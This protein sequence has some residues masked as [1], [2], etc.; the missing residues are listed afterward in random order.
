MAINGNKA[1]YEGLRS[2][3]FGTIGTGYTQIGTNFS[4]PV[5]I[6]IVTNATNQGLF[7]SYDGMTDNSWIPASSAPRIINYCANSAGA[8]GLLEHP[9]Q[10][11]VFV[12]YVT[13]AP[14]SGA[15]Y[16]ETIYADN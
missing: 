4:N 5:R 15:V 14:T 13:N 16:I 11:G 2:I 10:T 6:L 7:F 8:V 12:K 9:M 1:R 3:A